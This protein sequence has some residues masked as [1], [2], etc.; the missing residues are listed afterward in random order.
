MPIIDL[1][2]MGGLIKKNLMV[3]FN[4]RKKGADHQNAMKMCL[5]TRYRLETDKIQE[6][7]SW[8]KGVRMAEA[9]YIKMAHIKITK[10]PTKD[11]IEKDELRDLLHTMYTIESHLDQR[12]TFIR[13]KENERFDDKFS[14]LYDSMKAEYS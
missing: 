9:D 7:V 13:V 10:P 11:D 14:K 12:D 4:S 8:W 1:S 6:A 2:G 3:Y 5:A